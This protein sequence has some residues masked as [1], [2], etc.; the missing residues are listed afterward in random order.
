MIFFCRT[1]VKNS[2]SIAPIKSLF[3][4]KFCEF[5][6]RRPSTSS[7]TGT[8]IRKI[9]SIYPSVSILHITDF[10]KQVVCRGIILLKIFHRQIVT[11]CLF[12][13]KGK[14]IIGLVQSS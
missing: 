1:L 9:S 14:E 10:R 2:T 3:P 12:C 5:P 13:V 11:Y 4:K 7:G 6:T 8:G